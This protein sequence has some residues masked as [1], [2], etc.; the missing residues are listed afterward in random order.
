MARISIR[1]I[2]GWPAMEPLGKKESEALRR[3]L[4]R[5][6]KILGQVIGSFNQAIVATDRKVMVLKSGIMA[7]QTFGIKETSFDYRLIVGVEVKSGFAQGEFQIISAGFSGNQGNRN[8][9]KVKMAE[10]PN[11]VVFQSMH[12]EHFS[13]MA[14]KIR[15]TSGNLAGNATSTPTPTPTPEVSETS[16]PDQILALSE[17]HKIGV[18]TDEEFTS[19]KKDLL[20][21]M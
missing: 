7:G 21:R 20:D 16:I 12:L 15:E 3:H 13:K 4:A 6:E 17:L 2:D 10:E 5:D 14:A 19:K 11:G 18:L 8:R 1:Y 9:D